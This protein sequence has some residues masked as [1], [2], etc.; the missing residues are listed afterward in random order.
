MRLQSEIARQVAAAA[1]AVLLASGA[2]A[3]DWGSIKGRFVYTGEAKAEK[4]TP[5]KDVEFCGKHEIPD[6]AIVVGDGGGLA[7]VFVFL[8]LDRGKTVAI[9]PDFEKQGADPL[10]ID[11]KGCRFEPHALALWTKHPL[12]VS[13]SDPGIGHNT[14]G[15]AFLN[16]PT[17]NETVPND[18]PIV[19]T[20]EKSEP[21]PSKIACNVHPWMSAHVLVRD[22]PYMAV[23]AADGTFEINN[24]PAG[25]QEL[26]FWHEVPGNLKNLVVGKG[27]TDRKARLKVTIP[28]GQTLDLGDVKVAPSNL[29]K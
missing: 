18:K 5:N 12:K 3:A 10:A 19:K 20:F 14:N 27:K 16:N 4:I 6:E 28:A 25:A 13:N 22:N 7:N 9:H 23:S 26:A 8:A 1:V 11:N 24:I 17:F 2:G 29:G 15:T 21:I